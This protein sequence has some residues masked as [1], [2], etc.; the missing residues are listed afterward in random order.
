MYLQRQLGNVINGQFIFSIGLYVNKSIRDDIP[1]RVCQTLWHCLQALQI[2]L[3]AF[4]DIL[5]CDGGFFQDALN[6]GPFRSC[7]WYVLAFVF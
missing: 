3:E 5:A 4:T 1:H 6:P 2:V 7:I